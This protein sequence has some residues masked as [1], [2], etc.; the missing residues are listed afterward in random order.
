MLLGCRKCWAPFMQSV[1]PWTRKSEIVPKAKR[2]F[3]N[4]FQRLPKIFE[5]NRTFPR[6]DRWCFDHPVI[7]LRTFKR[8]RSYGNGNLNIWEN[9]NVIFTCED[10][11][12]SPARRSVLGKTVP[13]VSSTALSLRPGAVL[14]TSETVFPNTDR[15]RPVNNIFIYLWILFLEGRRNY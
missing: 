5:D 15:P 12:Y 13:D 3:P 11:C 6:R 1:Y 2:T 9:N 14:E 4:I 7:H 10:I 8:S